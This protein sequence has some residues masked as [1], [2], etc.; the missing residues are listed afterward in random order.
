MFQVLYRLLI[1]AHVRIASKM[2]PTQLL[3]WGS[4]RLMAL[5]LLVRWSPSPSSQL[6]VLLLDPH[7]GDLTNHR[8][9]IR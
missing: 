1:I 6:M 9:S 2:A 8:L 7:I 4:L 3:V 5:T